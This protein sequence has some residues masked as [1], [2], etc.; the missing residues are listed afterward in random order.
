MTESNRIA[1]IALTKGG[2]NIAL[3]I[4]KEFK[5][6]DI[7]LSEKLKSDF[8]DI[9]FYNSTLKE[10][11]ADLFK[12]YDSVIYIMALGIV[13][14]VIAPFLEN[15]KVDPAVVTIDETAQNVISTLSGHL[16]GAN[17]L[18]AKLAEI[19]KSNPVI[20]TAT[21]CQNKTA[22]DILAKRANCR[23]EPFS[24]LKLANSAIVNNETLNIF[25]DY[26]LYL[27]ETKNINI[28][29]L[30]QLKS[31]LVQKN[32]S[33]IISNKRYNFAKKYLQLIPQNI[34]IG[35]G[36]RRGVSSKKI[37]RAV[38]KTLKNL[39]LK[40][41]SIKNLATIDLKSDERG[42]LEYA[43]E[44]SFNIDIISREKIK[45]AELEVSYSDFVKKV[46]GVGSVCEPAALL[47]SNKGEL[48]F[49][50]TKFDEVTIAVVEEEVNFEK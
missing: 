44:K 41:N 4:K 43:E 29:P 39:N 30:S 31:D 11:T 9:Y 35:V 33:V 40:E 50:K 7:Y 14:R 10:L 17:K 12:K 22:I 47:S 38:N 26:N 28:Y 45:K 49:S 16:G 18:T 15:K 20:T 37:K 3:K 8:S 42:L 6:I 32:F 5:N 23:I 19:L 2:K 13:V 24:K 27:Q 36:C 46:V 1:V 34:T 25:S 48:I 21:D